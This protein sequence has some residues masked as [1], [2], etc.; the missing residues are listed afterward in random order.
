M[1]LPASCSRRIRFSSRRYSNASCCRWFAHPA[2]AAARN[3]KGSILVRILG[4]RNSI[5]GSANS[6]SSSFWT[7]RA[8]LVSRKRPEPNS[9][10]K[11][12]PLQVPTAYHVTSIPI[13]GR[14]ITARVMKR[15]HRREIGCR[16]KPDANIVD[17][18]MHPGGCFMAIF[19]S[20]A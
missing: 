10:A 19:V 7:L 11:P 3:R 6:P 2:I 4:Y 1:R 20:A 15:P 16:C 13:L 5:L 14:L 12:A 17:C 8:R 9:P 18:R